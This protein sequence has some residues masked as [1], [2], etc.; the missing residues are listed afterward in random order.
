MDTCKIRPGL[1]PYTAIEDR[2]RFQVLGVFPRR[3]AANTLA[4]LDRVAAEMPFPVQRVQ[5]DR[6]QEFFAYEVQD[7][8][9]DRRVK[10]RPNRPRAPHLNGKVERVQRTA[11]EE[12]WPTVD[13][14]DPGPA[15]PPISRPGRASTTT[16]ARMVLSAPA[17]RPSGSPS[18]R[19]RSPPLR[20]SAPPT[21]RAGS[22][23]APRT[24]ATAGSQPTRVSPD[25]H[26]PYMTP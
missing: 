13:P 14:K 18:W 19:R 23:S 20:P 11:R 26:R 16:T 12:F 22:S 5:T 2:S 24:P 25:Q 9:R 10:F 15:S 7:R 17:R 4:F 21:T 8:L 1:H 3:T 6:G